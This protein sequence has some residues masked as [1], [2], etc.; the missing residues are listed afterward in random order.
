MMMVNKQAADSGCLGRYGPMRILNALKCYTIA[1]L[2]SQLF[3]C[4]SLHFC[5]LLAKLNP[6]IHC[7]RGG[8]NPRAIRLR[9]VQYSWRDCYFT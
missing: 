2:V 4:R 5:C 1:N 3:T 8:A 7:T 6:K 9:C